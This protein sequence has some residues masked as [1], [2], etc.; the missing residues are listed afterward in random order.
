MFANKFFNFYSTLF[1]CLVINFSQPGLIF[2]KQIT[3]SPSGK[4]KSITKAIKIASDNDTLLI[5]PGIYKEGNIIINKKL[6]L[7]GKDYP[8]VDGEN[9]GEIFTVTSDSVIIKELKVINSGLSFVEDNAGIKLEGVKNCSVVNNVLLNNFFAVYLAKSADCLIENNKI[10]AHGTRETTSGNGIHLWYCKNITISNNK[11]SGHRDGIYFEFVESSKIHNNYSKDNIRYGLHFMFSDSC[12]YSNNTFE[13]N[14]AGV[15]VMYTHNIKMLNNL[16]LHNWGSASY[17]ILLK[18]IFDSQISNNKFLK[19]SSGIYLE[20]SNR[21]NVSHNDF[22]ENGWAL[23]LMANSMDNKFTDNNF[24]G[25]S[26]DVTTN[27]VQ[28]FNFFDHNYWSEYNGYDLN[29]NGIGDLPYR[30]VKLFS[31]LVEKNQPLLILHRSLFASV[32]D[33]TEK[34][35]PILTPESLIDK[36]PSMKRIK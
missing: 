24:I 31:L 25:N 36:H 10:E 30:P 4:I 29:K 27:S 5:M 3:I 22:I 6:V 14:G 13:N 15:A 26:F 32:L 33:L 35:F 2:T 16:F 7:L 18:E 9:N 8:L 28:N 20:G 17:G 19:N 21:I 34:I 11:I 23:R 1:L 12:V